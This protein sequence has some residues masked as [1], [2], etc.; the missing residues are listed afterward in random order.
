MSASLTINLT[1]SEA[2]SVI[3]SFFAGV[4]FS[5]TISETTAISSAALV[6]P[7]VFSAVV[8]ENVVTVGQFLATV[9]F[10]ATIQEGADISDVQAA[11]FLWELINNQQNVNWTNIPTTR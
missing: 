6:E 5:S 1:I 2:A 8:T 4:G 9:A 3:D 11:R 7:S 10:I